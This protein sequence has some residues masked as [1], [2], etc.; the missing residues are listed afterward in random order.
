MSPHEHGERGAQ[1]CDQTLWIKTK[2]GRA[3]TVSA[4]GREEEEFKDHPPLRVFFWVKCSGASKEKKN[5]Q[6]VFC[7][8][9]CLFSI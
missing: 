5:N 1:R 8:V 7:W 3:L 4:A 9:E 2:V 6:S